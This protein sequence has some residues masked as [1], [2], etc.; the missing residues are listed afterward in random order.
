MLAE[1]FE[2]AGIPADFAQC[3]ADSLVAEMGESRLAVMVMQ[4]EL[5]EEVVTKAS[6]KC[7]QGN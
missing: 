3:I 7:V 2:E 5:T 4:Q 6:M 1:Q